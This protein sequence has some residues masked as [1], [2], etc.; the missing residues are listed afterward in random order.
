MRND[1]YPYGDAVT[2]RAMIASHR[3]RHVIEIG[4]GYSSG[5]MLDIADE[6][7]LGDFR[8]TC[9]EPNA[10]RL[11]TMLRDGDESRVEIREANVQDVE[12]EL[13]RALA[14]GDILFIDSTHTLKTGSDVNFELFQILPRLQSGVLVHIH[15]CRFPFEYSD[16]QIFEKNYSWNEAYAVRALLMNSTRYRVIFYNSLFALQHRP[17]IEETFPP[18]L[19]DP[20][21]S[22]WLQV[23]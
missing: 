5:C 23:L 19:K 12:L 22:L 21:S 10:A 20:G 7:G 4:S 16:I 17:L 14:P 13:F 18:F 9:I 3:P 1:P 11:R 6:P 8:L 2:L 15:D